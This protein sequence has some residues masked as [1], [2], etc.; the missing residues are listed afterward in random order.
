M[1]NATKKVTAKVAKNVKKAAK[2]VTTTI[3]D[4]LTFNQNQLNFMSKAAAA[5][6]RTKLSRTELRTFA[7]EKFKMN[8]A[9]AYVIKNRALQTGERGQYQLPKDQIAKF[10]RS[11][12]KAKATKSAAKA[13]PVKAVAKKASKKKAEAPAEVPAS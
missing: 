4:T 3:V 10:N 6:G 5:Y 1:L 8:W 11:A 7:Q 2:E 9:P 12:G 13:K